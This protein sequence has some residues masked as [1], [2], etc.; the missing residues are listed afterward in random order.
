[1]HPIENIL[2][3]T[4]SEIKQ[5]VDVNT[6]VGDPV[7][8]PNGVTIIPVSKV[9][10]GFVSG[11]AEYKAKDAKQQ[12]SQDNLPEKSEYPF[13]GGSGTGISINPVAFVVIDNDSVKVMT[14]ASKNNFEKFIE[15]APQMVTQIKDILANKDK[16]NA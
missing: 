11:G 7:N 8:T 4:M 12:Q 5:M 6:I 3:T 13:C 2:Q 14:A 10:F 15:S 9:C 1:M 16:N